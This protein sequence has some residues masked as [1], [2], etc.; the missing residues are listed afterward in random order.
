MF[1][2]DRPATL[3]SSPRAR[4]IHAVTVA[5]PKLWRFTAEK[6]TTDPSPAMF[7]LLVLL[8][9]LAPPAF[10]ATTVVSDTYESDRRALVSLFESTNGAAWTRNELWN[11]SHPFCSWYGIK[12]GGPDDNKINSIVL[13]NN[14]LRGT[15]PTGLRDVDGAGPDPNDPNNPGFEITLPSN[16][17]LSGS[18]PGELASINNLAVIQIPGCSLEGTLPSTFMQARSLQYI[19]LSENKLSGALVPKSFR[20]GPLPWKWLSLRKNALSGRLPQDYAAVWP[21]LTILRASYNHLSGPIPWSFDDL[22]KMNQLNLAH[23]NVNGI[24]PAATNPD[25]RWQGSAITSINLQNN[26][27]HGS[28]PPAWSDMTRLQYIKLAHNKISG[29]LPSAWAGLGS[30][31]NLDVSH[32]RLSGSLPPSLNSMTSL[33]TAL[34]HRNFLIG[35]FPAEWS[36]MTSLELIRLSRNQM[37]GTLPPVWPANLTVFDARAN[38]LRGTLPEA[39]M[40]HAKLCVVLLDSNQLWGSIPRISRTFFKPYCNVGMAMPERWGMTIYHSPFEPA[41]LLHN[42]RLSGDLQ[43]PPADMP[44][45]YDRPTAFRDCSSEAD[46]NHTPSC[47]TLFGS[48]ANLT[49]SSMMIMGNMLNGP[50]PPWGN[51]SD[52]MREDV[53][54]L[55]YYSPY[56]RGFG[57]LLGST[58]FQLVFGFAALACATVRLKSIAN[59]QPDPTIQMPSQPRCYTRCSSLFVCGIWRSATNAITLA[60][61]SRENLESVDLWFSFGLRAAALATTAGLFSLLPIYLAG[62]TFYEQGDPLLRTTSSHFIALPI[63]ELALAVL[64]FPIAIGSASLIPAASRLSDD[65]AEH[66]SIGH[67]LRTSVGDGSDT[68]NAQRKNGWL[69]RLLW[70]SAWVGGVVILCIPTS[71]YVLTTVT[72]NNLRGIGQLPS[73]LVDILHKSMGYILVA[74]NSL[75]VKPLATVCSREAGWDKCTMLLV[76]RL[77]TTWMVPAVI[78]GVVSNAC[79]RHWVNLWAT[80]DADKASSLDIFGPSGEFGETAF[81]E[82]VNGTDG[83]RYWAKKWYPLPAKL[84][85]GATDICDRVEGGNSSDQCVRTIVGT[86]APLLV[87]KMIA[88][89]FLLPAT[90]LLAYRLAPAGW[91]SCIKGRVSQLRRRWR[92]AED[93]SHAA[94]VE[95][96]RPKLVDA[97]DV[98]CQIMTWLDLAIVFGPQIPL[99]LP[100]VLLATATNGWAHQIALHR[101][102]KSEFR[103]METSHYYPVRHQLVFS[104]MAQ[105]A[106]NAWVFVSC[107]FHGSR[108]VL[109]CGALTLVLTI[110]A[111]LGSRLG[112]CSLARML[113]SVCRIGKQSNTTKRKSAGVMTSNLEL[114]EHLVEKE[115]HEGDP[116]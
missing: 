84:V 110:W 3:A 9:A 77:L 47:S 78:L 97:D 12:C 11:T 42:N 63:G 18:I 41:L 99:I 111:A 50:T 114:L 37:D 67:N 90:R 8:F 81:S 57:V 85:A 82:F 31:N 24:L 48:H 70:R 101:L 32:N 44:I 95:P 26:S 40:D 25:S 73:W 104:V 83:N 100:L 14:N 107:D 93:A 74:T 103:C 20:G 79:G 38:R 71:V 64:A 52:P 2:T 65:M 45:N 53:R 28:L 72:P 39:L 94:V 68:V 88:S 89:A 13:P 27:L 22:S 21:N 105:Q 4:L 55:S 115:Q 49:S 102:G 96:E 30:V 51:F 43:A 1:E 109:V 46:F 33:Q 116:D 92:A 87:A 35:G 66:R 98:L 61:R 80:C 6:A 10:Q 19:L 29:T 23:N 113:P 56:T 15:L 69:K 86:L 7:V 36:T 60:P 17:G 76:S 34:L 54:F 58:P 5:N 62:G 106:L 75:L 108:G 112:R 91:S 16:P 59:H